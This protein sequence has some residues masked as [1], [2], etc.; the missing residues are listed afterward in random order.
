MEENVLYQDSNTQKSPAQPAPVPLSPVTSNQP[1]SSP[2]PSSSPP[3]IGNKGWVGKILKILIVLLILSILGFVIFRFV[4]P[5]FFGKGNSENVELNY[6]GLWE[7]EETMAPII[8]EFE[9]E[10]PNIRVNYEK[11]DV[12]KYRQTVQTRL[13][14]GDG[15][16]VFLFHNSWTPVVRSYLSP[17]ST[18][19][20]N[21]E[22]FKSVYYPVIQ[23][24]L[25]QKGAIYGIPMGF[26]TLAMFVNDDIFKE[27]GANPPQTWEDFTNTA[28]AV[29][30]KD[31]EERITTYGAGFGTFDNVTHAPDIISVLFAQNKVNQKEPA[32][33]VQSLE[34]ALRFYTDFVTGHDN[35]ETVWDTSAPSSLVAFAGGKLAIYFGYSWD[36]FLIKQLNPELKFSI[37]PMPKLSGDQTVAS[38][39]VNGVSSKSKNQEEAQEFLAFLAK[40]ETQ[41]MLYTESSKQRLFGLPPARRD[42]AQAVKDNPLVYPFVEQGE[43][44]TSSYFVSDTFDEGLNDQMNAYLGNSVRSI[45]GNTSVQ[46]AVETLVKGMNQVISQYGIK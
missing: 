22:E 42:M 46:T 23:K 9:K 11:K 29:T 6:W 17:V 14:N 44:A 8:A 13:V 36:V 38:Y 24:D 20:I 12:D 25:V 1:P 3:Q 35:I 32:K 30:V 21:P 26:D 15:P 18:S 34:E 19:V 33:T 40:K 45:V 31:E 41:D 7:S 37:Y 2:Q 5:M 4:V 43:N 27:T 10:H 28:T 39:W 16:D